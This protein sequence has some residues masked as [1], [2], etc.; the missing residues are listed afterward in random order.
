MESQS[1]DCQGVPYD[2]KYFLFCFVSSRIPEKG[3]FLLQCPK[4]RCH[5]FLPHSEAF[6][7]LSLYVIVTFFVV[8][9]SFSDV[10]LLH[11]HLS[12]FSLGYFI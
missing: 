2:F 5:S 3:V 10:F 7:F 6:P 9:L 8:F 11:F 4:F 12:L 1:L